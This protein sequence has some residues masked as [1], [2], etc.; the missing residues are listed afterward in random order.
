MHP[1]PSLAPPAAAAW[2]TQR[3]A[4]STTSRTAERR[5]VISPPPP[6]VCK[7]GGSSSGNPASTA[8]FP[9]PGHPARC[10]AVLLL[11]RA[12]LLAAAARGAG[13]VRDL[14]R[15]LL[16]HPLLA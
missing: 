12:R 13:R 15:A 14:R 8:R 16:R 5:S 4:P 2:P 7:R 6:P 3:S 10:R 9:A 1:E 11:L